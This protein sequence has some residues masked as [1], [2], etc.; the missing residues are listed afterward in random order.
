MEPCGVGPF[1][2]SNEAG[3][4]D[5]TDRVSEWA[6]CVCQAL[7]DCRGRGLRGCGCGLL[8]SRWVLPEHV[9][10]ARAKYSFTMHYQCAARFSACF[11][12]CVCFV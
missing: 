4:V 3:V 6:S 12:N 2:E 9:A 5:G 1:P 7:H 11:G 8:R 10:I